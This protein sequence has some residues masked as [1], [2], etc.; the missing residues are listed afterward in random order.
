MGRPAKG[1]YKRA[2]PWLANPGTVGAR[3]SAVQ[4]SPEGAGDRRNRETERRLPNGVMVAGTNHAGIRRN[5]GHP[6]T[7]RIGRAVAKGNGYLTHGTGATSRVS[8]HIAARPGKHT[9]QP[10][11]RPELDLLNG[12][13]LAPRFLALLF[14]SLLWFLPCASARI[15]F[16]GTP[17]LAWP[18]SAP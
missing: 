9:F 10:C 12:R 14:G 1:T 8:T 3:S 7:R 18:S 4:A 2:L 17:G 11:P 15:E 6:I 5:D 13:A 16:S